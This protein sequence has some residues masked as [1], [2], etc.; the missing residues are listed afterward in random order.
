MVD[1][2]AK[3][4][5]LTGAM[6]PPASNGHKPGSLH[7]L[8]AQQA[9]KAAALAAPAVPA[10]VAVTIQPKPFAFPAL[11]AS[12]ISKSIQPSTVASQ[13]VKVP[14]VVPPPPLATAG[15]PVVL[16]P[17]APQQKATAVVNSDQPDKYT[18][19]ELL[20]LQKSIELLSGA[21]TNPAI[22]GSALKQVMISLQ[23]NPALKGILAPTDCQLM[24]RAMRESYGVV[25][26]K[27]EGRQTARSGAA[28]ARDKSYAEVS[29]ELAD[30]DFAL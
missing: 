4:A 9:A 13:E 23:R 27:K 5:A 2:A 15:T 6:A 19:E 8:L 12:T 16:P 14:A 29:A 11:G 25:I 24:V 26:E 10:V 7:A 30:L 17:V 20:N 21:I 18:A 22:V 1:W 3:T 28:S